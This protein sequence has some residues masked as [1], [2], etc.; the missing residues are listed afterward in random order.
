ML[1]LNTCLPVRGGS[2]EVTALDCKSN[3]NIIV[4]SNPTLLNTSMLID[5]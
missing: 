1:K 3:E 5:M 2:Q 4:G